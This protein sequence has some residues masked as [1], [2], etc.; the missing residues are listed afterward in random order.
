MYGTITHIWLMSI[1]NLGKYI[2]HGLFGLGF[3]QQKLF[4]LEQVF[5]TQSSPEALFK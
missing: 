2:I 3:Q 5:P 1:E 4:V